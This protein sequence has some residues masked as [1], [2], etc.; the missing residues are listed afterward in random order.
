MRLGEFDRSGRRR[1]EE[2]GRRLRH[3]GR[4]RPRGRRPNARSEA[5]CNGVTL[6]TRQQRLH[7]D[8]SGHRPDL[9]EVDLRRRRRRQRAVVG[10]RGSR[11]RRAGGR[12]HRHLPDRRGPR[13]LARDASRS[14]LL[15]PDADP[16]D[17][18]RE[19]LR[20]DPGR[21]AAATTSTR[22]SS[23]GARAWPLRQAKRCLRCDYGEASLVNQQKERDAMNLP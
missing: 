23:R 1:P 20:P 13:L 14:N 15:R 22:S 4:S 9:G 6:K 2:G 21:A 7:P 18:P 11:G 16:I 12:R 17:T 10:R 19:Q 8:Q 5:I 3:R